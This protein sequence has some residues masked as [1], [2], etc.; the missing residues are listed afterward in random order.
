MIPLGLPSPFFFLPVT[1]S[2]LF[3]GLRPNTWCKRSKWPILTHWSVLG[4]P[5]GRSFWICAPDPRWRAVCRS[6]GGSLEAP[7]PA[8]SFKRTFAG[9][10]EGQRKKPLPNESLGHSHVVPF[11]LCLLLLLLNHLYL[12]VFSLRISVPHCIWVLE[13]KGACTVEDF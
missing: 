11:H 4:P 5:R 8:L 1:N 6:T 12:A 9:L 7:L 13:V 3:T 2:L 10:E